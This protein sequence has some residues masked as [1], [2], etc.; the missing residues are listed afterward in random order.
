M[1]TYLISYFEPAMFSG[2]GIGIVDQENLL[3]QKRAAVTH[4]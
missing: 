2:I 4:R 1:N 3:Y